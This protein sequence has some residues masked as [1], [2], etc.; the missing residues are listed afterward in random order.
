MSHIENNIK[1]FNL[2]IGNISKTNA[3]N[4]Y[5]W[6][7]T[8]ASIDANLTDSLL[9]D[10]SSVYMSV[11]RFSI[12]LINIPLSISTIQTN[13]P[14]INKTI[15]SFN[16]TID[17]TYTSGQQFIQHKTGYEPDSF[18]SSPVGP[19]QDF[20]SSYYYVYTITQLLSMWN[21]CLL[22]CFNAVNAVAPVPKRLTNPPFFYY[23]NGLICLYAPK[24]DNYISGSSSLSSVGTKLWFN[25]SMYQYV[26][27]M[28]YYGVNDNDLTGK[29]NYFIFDSYLSGADEK[30]I[31]GITYNTMCETSTGVAYYSFL[32]SIVI[33]TNMNIKS[34]VYFNSD[35]NVPVSNLNYNSILTDFMPDV[36]KIGG[37]STLYIYNAPSI[38]SRL[39]EFQQTTPLK[40]ISFQINITDKFDNMYKLY[41]YKNVIPATIKIGFFKKS[42]FNGNNILTK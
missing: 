9:D 36:S 7:K 39:F 2:S 11:Q 37:E 10:P 19:T 31:N 14:D 26:N 35:R 21:E 32:K 22:R 13:Q 4:P 12:P 18:P 17:N 25:N 33:S 40:N 5:G 16:I 15:Y 6:D 1:Y 34:E 24:L 30:I 20:S 28:N 3:G 8:T 29:D 41:N 42:L 38:S 27:T 23:S